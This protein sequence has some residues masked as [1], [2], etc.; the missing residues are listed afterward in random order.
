MAKRLS[1]GRRF[2]FREE[3]N[4]YWVIIL[5][6]GVNPDITIVLKI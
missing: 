5:I 3:E 1:G 6:I 2:K 4:E